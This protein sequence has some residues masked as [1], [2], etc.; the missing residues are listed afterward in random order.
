MS[1]LDLAKKR[2]SCRKISSRAVEAEKLQKIL[3]AA[4]LAPTAVNKQ[5]LHIWLLESSEAMAKVAQTT[6]YIFG[7]PVAFVVGSKAEDAF[8]RSSDKKNFADIDASIVATHMMLAIEDLGLATTWVGH[9]DAP[10]L[11]ELFPEMADYELVAIFPVGYAAGDA[12][13]SAR[14]SERKGIEALTDRL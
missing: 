7:A 12:A 10:K 4:N 11:K 5:P 8:V 3:E 13:P 14:H 9:F 1:F 6:P 2:Y